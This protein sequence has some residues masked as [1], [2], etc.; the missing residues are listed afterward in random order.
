MKSIKK[1]WKNQ[2]IGLVPLLL[3]LVLDNYFSYLQSFVV[4]VLF[5]TI[6]MVIFQVL[7][8]DNIYAFMLLPASF[9]FVLYSFFL[10]FL[11]VESVLTEYTPLIIEV[12]F[13]LV[14]ISMRFAKEGLMRSVR[15][16]NSPAYQRTYALTMLKEF[17]YISQVTQNLFTLHLFA[18]IL[19]ST[20]PDTM[21]NNWWTGFLYQDLGLI[22][23]VLVIVYEQIRLKML[24]NRLRKEMWLPVLNDKGAVIGSIAYS[25]SRLLPKKYYHPIIRVA[26]VYKG[27]LYLSKQ[28]ACSCVSASLLDYP[29]CRYVLFRQSI[30]DAMRQAIEKLKAQAEYI[31]PQLLIR[32]TFEN[33]RVKHQVSL[34]VIRLT[35][36]K[37]LEALQ[38]KGG[39]LWSVH[40]IEENLNDGIFS[41]YFEKEFS[42]LKN[43]VLWTESVSL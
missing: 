34:F 1:G 22:I 38:Y 20:M 43:T 2:A 42:Y 39:K 25:V 40:Q 23:G 15:N 32:Y 28:N 26:L 36:E 16:S 30:E 5:C 19:Y 10:I 3:F 29:F 4:S 7:R 41:E 24:Q 12:L 35:D 33:E 31:N 6:C 27:M 8:K 11:K 13:V 14:L 17:F 21:Q 9:T 37:D 18:I